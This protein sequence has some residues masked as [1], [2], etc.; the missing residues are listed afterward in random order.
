LAREERA[1]RLVVELADL[2]RVRV[3]ERDVPGERAAAD[4]LEARLPVVVA[5]R[6]ER[7]LVEAP[8]AVALGADRHVLDLHLGDREE[9]DARDVVAEE[10][11][12]L[13]VLRLERPPRVAG[14]LDLRRDRLD[15]RIA[16]LELREAP[17][18]TERIL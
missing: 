12:D 13:H 8:D 15:L 16:D 3:L 11:R 10:D 18:L 7:V 17:A 4:P 6:I 9:D 5:L 14:E 1:E 2:H